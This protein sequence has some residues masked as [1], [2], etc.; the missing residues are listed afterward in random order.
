MGHPAKTFELSILPLRK[1]VTVYF[2]TPRKVELGS[3][4]QVGSIQSVKLV[5]EYELVLGR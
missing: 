3:G 4:S 2:E 5:P 1:D